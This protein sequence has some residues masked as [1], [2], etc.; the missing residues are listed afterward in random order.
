MI[1]GRRFFIYLL[2]GLAM[3]AVIVI[4]LVAVLTSSSSSSDAASL[5]GSPSM[6]RV[7]N[8]LKRVP[9]I[10]GHNDLPFQLRLRYQDTLAR[11]RTCFRYE[12]GI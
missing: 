12:D 6:R 2:L 9:L 4:I 5:A 11:V 1:A 3:L 10:D 8:V 7:I